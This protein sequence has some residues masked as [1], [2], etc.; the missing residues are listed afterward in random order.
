M[1]NYLFIAAAACVALAACTKNEVK[2]VE[3][4]QEITYQ[5]I[6]TKAASNFA[7]DKHFTSYAYMLPSGQAW[8]DKYASGSAYI[9][10]ADI[11]YHT[12]PNYEWKA[13]KTYYWPKQGSLT[14][15]AWSTYTNAKPSLAGANVS[16]TQANGIQV[17]AFDITLNKNVDFLVAEVAKDKKANESNHEDKS[18]NTWA[19]GVPTVFKHALSKLVFK[20]QTV[21]GSSPYD[22]TADNVNFTVKS[23]KL[24]GV[25]NKLS[26][27]QEWQ[28]GS[29]AS[30]H[31]WTDPASPEEIE[32]VPVFSGEY[33]ASNT[34]TPLTPASGTDYYIVIPQTFDTD[35]VLEIVYDITTSFTG[36]PV[37]ETVTINDKKL[38]DAYTQWE[39]GKEYTLTIKLGIDEV[40]WDPDVTAWTV[41]SGEVTI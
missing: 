2:P 37:T 25:N 33:I 22:Y 26:Y 19:K 39:P 5:T 6:D 27:S 4:D 20:V 9:A 41:G 38:S 3:V 21:K 35:D 13:D 36:T 23:I 16:C 14:F 7:S 32:E 11:Y 29:T 30:K 18:S 40:L 28:S 12:S 17:D 24:K 10:D 34:A 8:D 1:R 31:T 15:F